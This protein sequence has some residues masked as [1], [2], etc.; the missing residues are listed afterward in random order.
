MTC[1]D[2]NEINISIFLES[3]GYK[4]LKKHR[5]GQEYFFQNPIREES[6]PSFT[7]NEKKNLW[8]DF[9]LGKG[10]KL[11]DLIIEKENTDVKGALNWLRNN[12][13]NFEVKISETNKF[14]DFKEPP[15][16]Y[17]FRKS[18]RIFSYALKD[19]LKSRNI[20]LDI[21][22]EYLQEIRYWDQVN[23]K[24]YFTLGMRNESGGYS[25]RN[26]LGKIVLA[27]NDIKY[28]ATN[29]KTDTILVFEGI[30]DFLSYLMLKDTAAIKDDVIILN[31]LAFAKKGSL[32]ISK[33]N[34]IKRIISFLDNPKK[35]NPR[36]VDTMKK[37]LDMLAG[38]KDKMYVANYFY[39]DYS[40]VAE[41]WQNTGK[42][43]EMNFE[44]YPE[45]SAFLFS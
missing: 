31:T 20:N 21:A 43:I 8:Y 16:R 18:T 10:G 5:A 9:G 23:E 29:S 3:L 33:L 35:E 36:S 45:N 14:Q 26:Q 4:K 41:Y 12:N 22:R 7:V 39:K 27:P 17:Q 19:Y 44:P 40:D 1:K 42:A 2:A 30:F 32:K 34:H 15:P 38:C 24:E 11:V 28:I 37:A 25:T 13:N 6:D